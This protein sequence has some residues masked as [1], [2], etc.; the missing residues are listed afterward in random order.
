MRDFEL[1]QNGGLTERATLAL[2]TEVLVMWQRATWR[3]SVALL[4]VF[5]GHHL[6]LSAHSSGCL[7]RG[8]P[9]PSSTVCTWLCDPGRR[10]KSFPA[11]HST[12]CGHASLTL[13]NARKQW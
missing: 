8:L 3:L 4:A 13:E 1:L 12:P 11:R 10:V 2:G 6:F 5:I 7:P 9:A